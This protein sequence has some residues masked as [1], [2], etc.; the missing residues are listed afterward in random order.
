MRLSIVKS[1]VGFHGGTVKAESDGDDRGAR[2]TLSLPLAAPAASREQMLTPV[3]SIDGITN[4]VSL[5]RIRVL[6]VEDESDAAEFVKRLL[7]ITAP[8]SRSPR[9]W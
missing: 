5:P 6:V 1:L 3:G 2:F 8:K 7:E 9:S 4:G